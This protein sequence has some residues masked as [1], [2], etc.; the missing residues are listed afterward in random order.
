MPSLS[1]PERHSC[2][3]RVSHNNLLQQE[4]SLPSFDSYHI[5]VVV[6]CQVVCYEKTIETLAKVSKKSFPVIVNLS[7]Y[8]YKSKC[9]ITL[10]QA[11]GDNSGLL[12]E[13]PNN[14]L[15]S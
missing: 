14:N 7:N 11:Q 13:A 3:L 8:D 5:N 2:L 12:K 1:H 15:I 10:R 9:Y 6:P 4:P